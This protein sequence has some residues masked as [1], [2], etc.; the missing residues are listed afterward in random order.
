MTRLLRAIGASAALALAASAQTT[1]PVTTDT[2]ST[3]TTDTTTSTDLSQNSP[4]ENVKAAAVGARAPGRIVTAARTRHTSL[5][6]DRLTFQRSGGSEV[7]DSFMIAS[8][9]SSSSSTDLLSSLLGGLLGGGDLS[10]LLG[11]LTGGTGTTDTTGD[12]TG[13]TSGLPQEVIDMITNAGINVNDIPSATG[14]VRDATSTTDTKT[15]SRA[16]TT[17]P[18]TQEPFRVRWANAM[19]S[20][21]FTQLVFAFSTPDFRSTIK[22]F[23]RPILRP[24]LAEPGTINSS[25]VRELTDR[26]RRA[27]GTDTDDQLDAL[28]RATGQQ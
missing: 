23:I 25:K 5:T 7:P 15:S 26:E 28:R 2:N 12:T 8:N 3:N 24:D 9:S 11:G 14:R 4:L 20:T 17:T 10:S 1:T 21:F 18:T 19:L 6:T 22:D 27:L 13:N 16:Q